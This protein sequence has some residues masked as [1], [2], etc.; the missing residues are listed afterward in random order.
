MEE[1]KTVEQFDLN[2]LREN[3]KAIAM[4]KEEIALAEYKKAILI[5]KLQHEVTT[6][7]A[8]RDLMNEKYGVVSIDLVS[9]EITELE[10][11]KPDQED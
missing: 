8:L 4:F 6:S 5:N 11:G 1:K 10:D 9:G 7:E 2:K 3:N